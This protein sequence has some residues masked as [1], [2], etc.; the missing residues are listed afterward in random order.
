MIQRI[1]FAG[2]PAVVDCDRKC[3]KAWGM[4]NRPRTQLSDDPDDYVFLADGELGKAP[5]DPGTC[6]GGEAKPGNK[7]TGPLNKWCVRECER[8]VMADPNEELVLP[9]FDNPKPNI[10]R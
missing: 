8:C 1:C 7:H 4:N 2:Q 5:K 9:D 10:P 6:E 3:R